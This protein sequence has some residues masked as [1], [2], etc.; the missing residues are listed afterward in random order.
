MTRPLIL[1]PNVC[2]ALFVKTG[3]LKEVR[4]ALYDAGVYSPFNPRGYFDANAIRR[5][6]LKVHPE[7]ENKLGN[8]RVGIANIAM[9]KLAKQLNVKE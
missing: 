9:T 6:I 8:P 3:S 1:N 7:L 4:Q 2:Y 5:A